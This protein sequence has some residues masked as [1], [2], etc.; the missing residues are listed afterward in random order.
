MELVLKGESD[1]RRA[2]G[3]EKGKSR[4]SARRAGAGATSYHLTYYHLK[5]GQSSW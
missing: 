4:D 5:R 2:E 1:K 3:Y